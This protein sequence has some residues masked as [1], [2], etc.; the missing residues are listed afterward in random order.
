LNNIL[1]E[2]KLKIMT[3][4]KNSLMKKKKEE[5]VAIILRKDDVEKELRTKVNELEGK[6]AT[7]E[8]TRE[9][10]LY[11]IGLLKKEMAEL[12]NQLG[13]KNKTI[14]ELQET[15]D[16]NVDVLVSFEEAKQHLAIKAFII[17][18]GIPFIGIAINYI[19]KLI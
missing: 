6:S 4:I 16:D 12:N 18:F 19:V 7:L 15:I 11:D 3:E 13:I 1:K 8:N 5:L 14:A 2:L 9:G 10:L 17:G